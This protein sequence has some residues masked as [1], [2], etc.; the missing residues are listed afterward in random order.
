MLNFV[1]G[2]TQ[3]FSEEPL[4]AENVEAELK[5]RTTPFASSL[6]NDG[7]I[8]KITSGYRVQSDRGRHGR[9]PIIGRYD[10]PIHKNAWIL[11][12]LSSR[13]LLYH[14]VYGDTLTSMILN[15]DG[16]EVEQLDINWWHKK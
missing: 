14:A 11:T 5:E 7:T 15:L 9:I 2:A 13:G 1:A 10:T 12:G 4:D 6:W 8:H 3:E 16:K